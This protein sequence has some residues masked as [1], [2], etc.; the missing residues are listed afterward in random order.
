VRSELVAQPR[1]EAVDYAGDLYSVDLN[2]G[3]VRRLTSDD[4]VETHPVVSPDG[5]TIAFSTPTGTT[6]FARHRENGGEA[7]D[8]SKDEHLARFVA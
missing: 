5:S 6:R 2:G 8:M 4:D 1:I 7:E 3:A